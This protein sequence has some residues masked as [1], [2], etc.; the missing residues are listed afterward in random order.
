MLLQLNPGG[1]PKPNFLAFNMD[2]LA[3]QDPNQFD[4]T[5]EQ[6]MQCASLCRSKALSQR[7]QEEPLLA[8][9]PLSSKAG[10]AKLDPQALNLMSLDELTQL[11]QARTESSGHLSQEDQDQLASEMRCKIAFLQLPGV[12]LTSPR[13]ELNHSELAKRSSLVGSSND[14]LEFEA[15]Q[16]QAQL[17]QAT[18]MQQAAEE[19]RFEIKQR[20]ETLLSELRNQIAVLEQEKE[21]TK[22]QLE[23]NVALTP[24]LELQANVAQLEE[25]LLAKCFVANAEISQATLLEQKVAD[26]ATELAQAQK[27]RDSFCVAWFRVVLHRSPYIFQDDM[28]CRAFK[29]WSLC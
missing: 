25:Q 12:N 26:L 14:K 10:A 2:A 29:C 17:Q 13:P 4:S 9:E 21:S 16:L 19:A 1:V 22:G 20:T 18:Q 27:E 24:V 23:G 28:L 15:S 7:Q 6:Y 5:I 8:E 3:H 11:W